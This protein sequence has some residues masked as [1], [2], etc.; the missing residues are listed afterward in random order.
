MCLS[1]FY[2]IYIEKKTNELV[3]LDCCAVAVSKRT[4]TDIIYSDEDNDAD[5]NEESQS[6]KTKKQPEW[7]EEF[8]SL[9]HV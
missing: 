6:K 3:K 7:K 2:S 5:Q 8:R 9:D 1:R 4:V